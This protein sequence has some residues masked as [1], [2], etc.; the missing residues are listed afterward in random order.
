MV[1]LPN[2][3]AIKKHLDN[4]PLSGQK[5]LYLGSTCIQSDSLKSQL[6]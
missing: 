6:R 2:Q 3:G 4:D 1:S 5:K